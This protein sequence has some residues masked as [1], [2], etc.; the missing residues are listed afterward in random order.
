[1]IAW[2]GRLGDPESS[3]PPLCCLASHRR[4]RLFDRSDQS[5]YRTLLLATRL[6]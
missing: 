2:E 3:L 1:M 5:L 4:A 6:H